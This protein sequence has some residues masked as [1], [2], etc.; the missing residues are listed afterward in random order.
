MP[1]TIHAQCSIGWG[2]SATARKLAILFYKALRF[3]ITYADPGASYYEDRYR[4]RVLHHLERR[5]GALGF[6]L[7]ANPARNE[8]VS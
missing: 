8:G 3:G 6:V 1:A 2:F 7:V 5:A 4:Q